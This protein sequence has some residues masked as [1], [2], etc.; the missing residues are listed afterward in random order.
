MLYR[1]SVGLGLDSQV[2]MVIVV[3][4]LWVPCTREEEKE[5]NLLSVCSKMDSFGIDLVCC[6]EIKRLLRGL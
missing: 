2:Y 3:L 6:W 4:Q 5:E 1:V